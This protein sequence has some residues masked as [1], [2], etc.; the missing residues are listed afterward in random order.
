MLTLAPGA[1][2]LLRC[3]GVDTV[4]VVAESPRGNSTEVC[5]AP[6]DPLACPEKNFFE[7]SA[8]EL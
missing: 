3:Q 8:L 2:G 6:V 7:V 1:T 4:M 5:A